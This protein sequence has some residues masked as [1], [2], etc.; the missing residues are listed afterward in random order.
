M[1]NQLKTRHIYVTFICFI[2]ITINLL[3]S[4]DENSHI[5]TVNNN[6]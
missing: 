6:N 5:K 2:S 1:T 3:D 4:D